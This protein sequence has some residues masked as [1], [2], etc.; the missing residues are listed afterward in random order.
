SHNEVRRGRG[1]TIWLVHWAAETPFENWAIQ[2]AELLLG[3]FILDAD[4]NPVG[5]EEISNG[6]AFTE[7]LGIGCHAEAGPGVAGI[8][9]K[10]ALQL[11]SGLRGDRA[12]L[13]DELRRV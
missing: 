7:E 1:R 8:H 9:V 4:D 12:L 10:G 11:L 6:R 3:L 13:D 2:L 5:M